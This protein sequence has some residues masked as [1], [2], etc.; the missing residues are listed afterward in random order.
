MLYT[1]SVCEDVELVHAMHSGSGAEKKQVV[2]I[3]SLFA[4]N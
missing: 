3:F 4:G 2:V 1:Q